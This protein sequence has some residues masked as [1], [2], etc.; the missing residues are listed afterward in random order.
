MEIEEIDD[1][2]VDLKSIFFAGISTRH[3][4]IHLTNLRRGRLEI[5]EIRE[6]EEMRREKEEVMEGSTLL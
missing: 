2:T 1:D 3:T 6:M 5:V 4:V